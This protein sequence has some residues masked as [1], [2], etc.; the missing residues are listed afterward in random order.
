MADHLE[1][2]IWKETRKKKTRRTKK[3]WN[4]L[5]EI[6][7]AP[8]IMMELNEVLK[9]LK[10]EKAAGPDENP[11]EFW[12]WLSP[13]AKEILLKVFNECFKNGTTPEA[14]NN[15]DVVYIFK[16]GLITK[17]ENYRPIS[18]VNT[19]YKIYASLLQRRIAK[20]LD[21]RIRKTQFGYRKKHSSNQAIHI[22]R[23]IT[24]LY[25][26][27]QASLFMVFLDWAKAFDS[28]THES[29]ISCLERMGVPEQMIKA[30]EA[31]YRDPT[32]QVKD[33]KSTS[34]TRKQK[35]GIKQGCPLSPYLFLIV[36]TAISTMYLKN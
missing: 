13:H 35:R 5:A 3:I 36:V 34:T 14:W 12:K 2:E 27:H 4:E 9:E 30:I 22:V 8:F 20:G 24:E 7:L 11:N 18:L 10:N 32:F 17:P 23:R 1:K 28:I 21:T 6:D 25:E 15:A 29:I 26:R 31:I 33:E 19:M 16:K